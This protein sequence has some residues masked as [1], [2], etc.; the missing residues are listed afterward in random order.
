M[1]NPIVSRLPLDLDQ[2]QKY[3]IPQ[4]YSAYVITF[5]NITA[6]ECDDFEN[7]YTLKGYKIFHS[8]ID[9]S[10]ADLFNMQLIVAKSEFIFQK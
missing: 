6:Q 1:S 9:R 2:Y 10:I 3:D 4:D 8:S 5:E 7:E